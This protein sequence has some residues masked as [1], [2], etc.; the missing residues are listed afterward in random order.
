VAS[1][2]GR[3]ASELRQRKFCT[4]VGER[5][6]GAAVSTEEENSDEAAPAR[7]RLDDSLYG[8]CT[9]RERERERERLCWR[10][11]EI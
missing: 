7:G 5:E 9:H 8:R 1:G 2:R 3:L 11:N 4:E 10:G 6:R